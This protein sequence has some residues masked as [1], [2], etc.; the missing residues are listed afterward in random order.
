HAYDTVPVT[1]G[2]FTQ[3]QVLNRAISRAQDRGMAIMQRARHAPPGRMR[4]RELVRREGQIAAGIV[5]TATPWTQ[6]QHRLIDQ[7]PLRIG[8][9]L[10]ISTAMKPASRPGAT[11]A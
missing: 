5:P 6:R 10:D 9:A 4:M 2:L 8:I 1:A 7:P 3:S 11:T